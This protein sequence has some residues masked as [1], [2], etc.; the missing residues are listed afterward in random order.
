MHF[1]LQLDNIGLVPLRPVAILSPLWYRHWDGM[2]FQ[3]KNLAIQ[4]SNSYVK[5]TNPHLS[6][7]TRVQYNSHL[8]CHIVLVFGLP[9]YLQYSSTLCTRPWTCVGKNSVC[10]Y[11][12]KLKNC[13][14]QYWY[15]SVH[16]Y[17]HVYIWPYSIEYCNIAC[18]YTCTYACTYSLYSMVLYCLECWY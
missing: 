5:R 3:I 11:F 7:D 18:T 6:Y 8:Y 10:H 13:N 12:K 16:V 9:Y 17:V 2:R 4:C 15:S 1:Q 14:I